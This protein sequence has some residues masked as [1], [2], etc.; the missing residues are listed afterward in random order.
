M[1]EITDLREIQQLEL[2]ILR[3]LDKVCHDNN[4]HFFLSNGTLL[5]AIK[6]GGFIPWD[7]DID[8]LMPRADYDKLMTIADAEFGSYQLLS[9]ERTAEWHLPFSKL[10]D[11]S[12]RKQEGSADFGIEIGVDIDI[13]PLDSWSGG[14]RQSCR[15]GF[16]RRG[17]SAAIE[18]D[19]TSPR[20]GWKRAVLYLFWC[21]SRQIGSNFFCRRIYR[22]IK[23]GYALTTP[24]YKGCVAWSLYGSRELIPAVVFDSSV[25]ISFEG[26]IYN[27][28]IGYKTYLSHLYGEYISD[29]P[30]EKQCT[31][32]AFQ[33]WKL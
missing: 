23:R 25:P 16:W 24:A 28:P 22:E 6:Y 12:T 17:V 2:G 29:P 11:M 21:I 18:K 14:Y 10:C 15:C 33:V 4:L 1:T 27:A 26:Q 32:H 7:D 13:F 19:F 20:T 3:Q 8:V 30:P 5:G 9:Q 31:H